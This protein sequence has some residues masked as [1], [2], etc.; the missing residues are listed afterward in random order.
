MVLVPAHTS[1]GG[2]CGVLRKSHFYS[3]IPKYET[4]HRSSLWGRKT[5]TYHWK[6]LLSDFS[7]G[8]PISRPRDKIWI[9]VVY[10]GAIPESTGRKGAEWDME[11]Q[12]ANTET[13][14]REPYC[15]GWLTV[16]SVMGFCKIVYNMPQSCST[17]GLRKLRCVSTHS[18]PSLLTA[19]GGSINS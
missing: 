19:T 13:S 9:Q 3:P 16:S 11:G 7:R 14:S 4:F 1:Y 15:C 17:P 12:E 8:S 18:H 6:H 10:L 5:H 2:M